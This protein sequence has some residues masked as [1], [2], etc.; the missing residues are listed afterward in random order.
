MPIRLQLAISF[1][2]VLFPRAWSFN[3]QYYVFACKVRLKRTSSFA[4]LSQCIAMY[5]KVNEHNGIEQHHISYYVIELVSHISYFLFVC[6]FFANPNA[7]TFHIRDKVIIHCE[8][9]SFIGGINSV[10]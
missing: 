8:I 6:F 2:S 4:F 1:F 3:L 5:F 9:R 7:N 10:L